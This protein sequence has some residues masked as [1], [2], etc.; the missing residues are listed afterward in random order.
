ML[1]RCFPLYFFFLI[2]IL[3]ISITSSIAY[4]A[5]RSIIETAAIAD[6]VF[7]ADVIDVW[8]E[9]SDNGKGTIRTCHVLEVTETFRG[10]IDS[11]IVV[12]VTPGGDLP[13]GRSM[14]VSCIPKIELG[15]HVLVHTRVINDSRVRTAYWS[16]GI[17]KFEYDILGSPFVTDGF[18][19]PIVQLGLYE[20]PEYL[21]SNDTIVSD[22]YCIDCD[23]FPEPEEE[24]P[25]SGLLSHEAVRDIVVGAVQHTENPL[26]VETNISGYVPEN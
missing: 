8:A 25:F 26:A 13:D 15:D 3:L 9:E 24:A 17:L 22:D 19:R 14:S 18:G 12:L 5:P 2:G 4:A 6:L 23:E 20:Y 11:G 7:E 16:P 21:E 10:E 1:D